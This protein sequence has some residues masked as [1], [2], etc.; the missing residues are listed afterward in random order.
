MLFCSQRF[1][2]FF[3]AVFAVY[4]V[5]DRRWGRAASFL[6]ASLWCAW[7]GW[8]ALASLPVFPCPP[9]SVRA[10][11]ADQGVPCA[12]AAVVALTSA[13]AF[14][15]GPDRGRVWLLLG[16]SFVFYASWSQQLAGIVCATTLMDYLIARGLEARSAPR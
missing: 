2:L 3:L 14:K 4:W 13:A 10:A 12:L 9:D 7:A 1:I 8:R 16:A 6:T 5:L 15:V 11:L